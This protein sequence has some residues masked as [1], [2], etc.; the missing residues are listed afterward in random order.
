MKVFLV[1]P[2]IN[3]KLTKFIF[4]FIHGAKYVDLYE[5][6]RVRFRGVENNNEK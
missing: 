2:K 6:C 1:T 5:K 3:N 4:L